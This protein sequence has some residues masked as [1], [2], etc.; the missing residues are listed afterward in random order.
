NDVLQIIPHQSTAD[1]PG[2]IV[3][4][5]G[6]LDILGAANLDMIFGL[7][8]TNAGLSTAFRSHGQINGL[9]DVNWVGAFRLEPHNSP[10]FLLDSSFNLSLLEHRV[11]DGSV[12]ISDQGLAI[13]GLLKLFPDESPVNVTGNLNG[14]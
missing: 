12:N 1:M 4:L 7:A 5:R 14:T 9:L 2:L 10:A 11:L 6:D 13:N 8:A 3:F